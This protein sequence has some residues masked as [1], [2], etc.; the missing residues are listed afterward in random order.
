M[1]GPFLH[2][3]YC[4]PVVFMVFHFKLF[5]FYFGYHVWSPYCLSSRGEGGHTSFT[6][7]LIKI[8]YIKK[9]KEDIV[10]MLDVF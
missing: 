1:K 4:L 2:E 10:V 8:L 3:L 9:H 7:R 5:F 6:A